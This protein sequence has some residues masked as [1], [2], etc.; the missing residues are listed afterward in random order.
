MIV[1]TDPEGPSY[2]AGSL[3][4]VTC[5]TVGIVSSNRF[6]EW[7]FGCSYTGIFTNYVTGASIIGYYATT[8]T[9]CTD[10]YRCKVTD[11]TLLTSVVGQVAIETVT[12]NIT[13]V[14]DGC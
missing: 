12:G 11:L 6:Y 9:I 14:M 10:I 5:S 13:R 8:T 1:T 3:F 7:S 4:S 2:K